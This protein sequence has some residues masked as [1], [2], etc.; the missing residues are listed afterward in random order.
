MSIFIVNSGDGLKLMVICCC[1]C[2]I[3]Y[4]NKDFSSVYEFL[5]KTNK[6]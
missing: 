6:K 5:S 1:Y 2:V 3:S 4:A